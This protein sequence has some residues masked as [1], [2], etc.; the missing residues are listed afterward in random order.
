MIFFN[1]LYHAPQNFAI[2]LHFKKI[3]FYFKFALDK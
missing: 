1:S 2:Y 3:P